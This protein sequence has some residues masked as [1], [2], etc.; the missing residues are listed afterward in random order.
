MSNVDKMK[1]DLKAR[2]DKN[3]EAA[4]RKMQDFYDHPLLYVSLIVSG[5]LSFVAGASIGLGA[6]MESDSLVFKTSFGN[7]FFAL[8]YGLLFPYFFEFGLWNWLHKML[9]REPDNL[10]QQVTSVIMVGITFVGTFITAIVASDVLVTAFGFFSSFGSI[11]DAVQRWIAFAVPTMIMINI[12]SGEIYRQFSSVAIY[13]RQAEMELREKVTDAD[14]NIQL[15]EVEAK[16]NIAVHA[17]EEFT[18]H[19]TLNAPSIGAAQGAQRWNETTGAQSQQRQINQMAKD[20]QGVKL[21]DDR[22]F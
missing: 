2:A 15:A 11:P 9:H 13:R 18:R 17:A 8:I 5:F 12:A 20:V 6:H 14:L 10:W 21:D 3:K 4:R 19:A 1:A 22:N 7:I 16:K